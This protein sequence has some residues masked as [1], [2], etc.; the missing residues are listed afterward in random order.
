MREPW[1]Y[2][3]ADVWRRL[4]WSAA[5]LVFLVVINGLSEGLGITLL[6]PLLRAVGVGSTHPDQAITPLFD[7]ALAAVGLTPT[8][9]TVLAILVSTFL[10][11]N[12]I[13]LGQSW[14][15]A[16]LQNRYT[17]IWRTALMDAIL[18]AR[19]SFFVARKS[20]ELV[21]VV[22]GETNR[23]SG[24]F[25]LSTQILA[26]LVFMIVYGGLAFWIS[27]PVT[28]TLLGLGAF[29][30]ALTRSLILRARTVG[31]GL[32][33][34][35]EDLQVLSSEFLAGAKLI[36]ASAT[37]EVASR[38]FTE[39]VERLRRLYFQSS[40]HP[41]LLRAAFEFWG[42]TALAGTLAV[43][44][45]VLG[46]D[47]A[48]VVVV[49]ALFVR[50][51]PRLSTLQQ[52]WQ[53]LNVMLPAV[54]MAA[55]SLEAAER[56]ADCR[57]GG[58]LPTGVGGRVEIAVD[59]L[60]VAYGDRQALR[61]VSVRLPAGR[62]V[63]VVGSS[64][65]GK[66][67]LADAL[68][69]LVPAAEGVIR[70]NGIALADLPLATWRRSVGYVSQETFLFHAS[71][72]DNLRWTH[73]EASDRDLE[74]AARRALAH[75]FVMALPLGYDT[76]VG[77]R[78]VRLSGGERQRLGLA[79]ALVGHPSLLVL[80]EATSALDSHSERAVLEAIAGLHGE[81]TIL[82]I[83]HRLSTVR[84]VDHIYVLEAGRVVEEGSWDELVAGATRFQ[85]LWQLQNSGR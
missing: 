36:K 41:N 78:A 85:A 69:G 63:A 61:R 5:A 18:H 6:L 38:R 81:T 53:A 22:V 15:A 80:D 43:G 71:V 44:T 39:V 52:S 55:Q 28:L 65:S 29:L 77:D 45:Q 83:A 1:P 75:D 46:L 11:Q 24:A 21:N 25:Y 40:F 68:L 7:G 16:D 84:D 56:D 79:R 23:L 26:A 4:R 64:G 10:V 37:E 27:W 48:A 58:D 14:L 19:W 31:E 70:I 12:A 74:E 76:L 9:P 62:T 2:L 20:G 34:G 66:S 42:I 8:W 30:L 57:G 72:R 60:S 73:P 13:F 82:T 33:K 54:T 32:S 35:N 49:I 59:S 50:F 51:Y 47:P 17:A 3:L 67:T